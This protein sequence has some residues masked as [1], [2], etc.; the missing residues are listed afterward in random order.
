MLHEIT[1]L[2]QTNR[3]LKKRWF[4]SVD[5]DLFVWYHDSAPV[6]FQLSYNKQNE[7]RAISWDFHHGFQHYRIDSGES[8]PHQY[9]RTP[10]MFDF[11]NQENL[12][13]LARN[14]LA[15]SENIDIAVAD[16][17][18]ARLMAYPGMLSQHNAQHTDRIVAAKNV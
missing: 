6:K 4:N 17:I 12:P 14:F 8:Y 15:A 18:Y 13:E 5:M 10:I 2:R 3:S 16:F 7:E 9:K 1:H 11:C